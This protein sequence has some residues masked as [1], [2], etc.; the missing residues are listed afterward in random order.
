MAPAR[1][2]EGDWDLPLLPADSD[3]WVSG[4]SLMRVLSYLYIRRKF[5]QLSQKICTAVPGYLDEAVTLAN[6]KCI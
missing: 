3:T 5:V 2:A 4:T 1:A 6:R